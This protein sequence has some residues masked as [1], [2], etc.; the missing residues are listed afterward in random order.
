MKQFYSLIS[1]LLLKNIQGK[2]N[3]I[4]CFSL[5]VHCETL[6]GLN[7]VKT[8]VTLVHGL[9]LHINAL[10]NV[11]SHCDTETSKLELLE[12]LDPMILNF[13]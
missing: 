2:T 3:F 5:N 10:I 4:L 7:N 9:V 11:S 1:P 13:N 6:I 12:A 8:F